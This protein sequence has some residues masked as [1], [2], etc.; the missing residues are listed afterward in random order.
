MALPGRGLLRAVVARAVGVPRGEGR[1][2]VRFFG[3]RAHIA[4][5]GLHPGGLPESSA[6]K[7]AEEVERRLAALPSVDWAVVNTVLGHAVVGTGSEY[8]GEAVEDA[9][10]AVVEAVEE[11]H[12]VV[13][14]LPEHPASGGTTRR[15]ASAVAMHVA[16]APVAA[17]AGLTRH[18][19]VPA[20]IAALVPIVDTHPRLRHLVEQ[21]VGAE[22]AGVLLS[23][24]TAL[25]QAG[26]GGLVGTGV[27]ALRHVLRAREAAA[28]T[29]AW[30]AA[31]PRL[32]GNPEAGA[33]RT[34][35]PATAREAP[36]KPGPV[37]RY[38]DRAL[39]V[40]TASFAGS[41]LVTRRPGRAV[42][43][44]LAAVPK[45]P[46]LAREGFACVFGRGMARRGVVVAA[47]EALRRLDR[48][49]TVLLDTDVLAT[50]V[51]RPADL[52]ALDEDVPAG[53]LA[54]TA[55]RLFDGLS[56]ERVQREGAWALGPVDQLSLRGRT[57]ERAQERLRRE[58]AG[59]VLGLAHDRRLLAVIS[60]LPEMHEAASAF[61]SA[62]HAAGLRVVAAGAHSADVSV[63]EADAVAEADEGNEGNAGE[64]HRLYE[65][66]RTL[67]RDGDGVL[68]ISHDRR[69]L[70]AADVGVGFADARERPPWGADLY[71]DGDPASAVTIVDACRAARE[72]AHVGVRLAQAAAVVGATAVLAGRA[73]RP[74]ARGVTA[75]NTA[76]AL[77]TLAG[78]WVAVR[79]LR[80]PPPL[81][82]PRHPWHA[83]DPA[84]ALARTRSGDGGL[85]SEEARTRASTTGDAAPGASL[86]RAYLSEMANPLTPVLGAGAAM[87]ASVGALL[88]AVVIVAVTALS[89]LFGGFQR[90]RTDRAVGRLRRESAVTAHVVRDGQETV[91]PA[92]ELAVGDVVNLNPGDV[93]PADARLLEDHHMEVDESALTGESL[94]VA[95]SVAPVLAADLGDRTSMVYEGTTVAAGRGRAVVVATGAA[96]EA[97]R[98]AAG[99][100]GTAPAAGV[101][102]RL[103]RITRTTLPVALG[104][105]AGVVGAGLL[106]G[107]PARATVGA[108]V[109]LAVAS[110]PEGLPF[111]VSAAQLAS[112]RRL[113]AR[114]A[115]LR[116]P[117]T[118]EAAG[119]TDVLC[120]DKTGTLTHGRISL[121]AVAA[122]G[123]SRRLE[124]LEDEQRAV[125]AAALRATPRPHNGGELEH[126]TDGAV[127]DGAGDAR[128]TRTTGAPG[129]RRT[130]S[131]PF[132]ANRVFHATRGRCGRHRILSVKGAPEEVVERCATRGG[133]HL[134][135]EGRNAVLAAGEELAA[136]G[137]RVLAVAELRDAPG[138]RLTDET[139]DGLDFRGFLAFAD[140]VRGTARDAVRRLADADVHIVMITGDHPGTA[141]SMARELGVLD[142]R[143]VV[144]GAELDD[145]D[146]HALDELLPDVGVVARGTP[147][148]KVRVVRAFQRLGRTV[149]MTGDGANDAP[150][151]RLADIGIAFGRR[152]TPAARAA[153]DLVVTDDRLETVLAAL[154]EGRAMWASVRETL[155]ILVGG[156]LG[157][158]AFTLLGA[159]AT[160]S[161]PLT[162]RQLLL[163]NLFT[164]LA[165][166]MAVA[167]RPPRRE[168]AERMLREGPEV[169]LGTALSEEMV[170]R[171]A[172]TALG[173]TA[174]WLAARFTGRATRARTVALVALVGAQLGQTLLVGGR[175]GSI[176]VSSLGSLAA[177]AAVVQTPVLSQFFGC[178]PLGPVAWGIAL[179]AAAGATVT[180]PFLPPLIT[181]VRTRFDTPGAPRSRRRSA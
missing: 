102:R 49:S 12:G 120:F 152:A 36:L 62:A 63:R 30:T 5:R 59:L 134:D 1:A 151:I 155:A 46:L 22:T 111:L 113:S 31:E 15:S 128:V 157:K 52:I 85:T 18:A 119:R 47:P 33:H 98:A 7:L 67:Q 75:F 106:R 121:V 112:A 103:A 71:L 123:R 92:E 158:I 91:A 180:S 105:A 172:A 55:H 43:A 176:A 24:I 72:T 61:V 140:R 122:D 99:G 116:H 88:D 11:A 40:A 76:A 51:H 154:V 110:V 143:R 82:T 3:R 166:A 126:A 60:V 9:L 164:D 44:A 160:G 64:A 80:R 77:G 133:R 138:G 147:V 156:N 2:R 131:L 135:S 117:R 125:L 32:T 161:S 94:P 53:E 65:S 16:A 28:E 87:S 170:C 179:S 4:V 167:L 58:G 48:I 19:P 142:G 165:P 56:P 153:A 26:S 171:A 148:H 149:A 93:V 69:A 109:G 144:T 130:S 101:E 34:A 173:A 132:E 41:L 29:A 25:G 168:A 175:S 150:A 54:A 178:A 97:G 70:L 27:D 137:H 159:A 21:A 95:K 79:L 17:L 146:D 74:A 129:W 14:P 90:Y 42:G 136:A 104:S 115:L 81:P 177:L 57:G 50:G 163:V 181:R 86:G 96:T 37:E 8:E 6:E 78:A 145:L 68:V 89:G 84:T 23:S 45:A 20:G 73:R 108:G 38:A 114:G 174:G 141:E 35:P 83:M 169:S 66:V 100:R 13:H 39:G 139:V 124:Q 10:T 162:A 118:I 107:R 127:T